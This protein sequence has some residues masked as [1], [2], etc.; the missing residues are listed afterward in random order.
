MVF[1]K[2]NLIIVNECLWNEQTCR[3]AV[4]KGHLN[5]L[6]YARENGCL[7][8]ELIFEDVIDPVNIECLVYV[9]NNGGFIP[10]KYRNLL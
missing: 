4:S 8:D 3:N 7:W 2:V 5:C 6:K 9:Y 1:M 10:E